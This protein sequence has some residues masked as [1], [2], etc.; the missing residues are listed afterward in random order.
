[1][2]TQNASSTFWK[3]ASS[4]FWRRG[5][6]F[7]QVALAAI[8]LLASVTHAAPLGD[9]DFAALLATFQVAVD[10]ERERYHIPGMTAAFVLPDGRLAKFASGAAD[11][12][13]R[14]AMSPDSRMLSGSIGKTIASAVAVK[15]AEQGVWSLDD[16]LSKYL[17]RNAWYARL[18]NAEHLTVRLLL[19]HR[20][21][22]ENYYDN[23]RFFELLRK[24]TAEDPSYAPTFETLIDFVC[25]RPPLFPPGQGFKYTDVG[26]L[27][28]GLA[29]EQATGTPYYE[30]ARAFFLDPVGL[31]LTSPSNVRRLPGLVQGYAN[32][33]NALLQGPTMIGADGQL[34]Y[35]P[36]I[37]FTAGGFVTNSG[38]LARW[39]KALY[40]S[41]VLSQASV[42][43]ILA[44]PATDTATQDGPAYYGLGVRV[45]AASKE[46][47]ASYGH[48][49]YIPG[50]RSSM[51]YYPEFDVAIALQMNTED[52]IWE[53]ETGGKEAL[54]SH[55]DPSAI[56]ERLSAIVLGAVRQA[57]KVN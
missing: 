51:R 46:E 17:G 38:D 30:T 41:R 25:D 3:P 48:D 45:S 56:R 6:A 24:K 23:P 55:A 4:R 37:E 8:G 44:R 12:E 18:P 47:P 34:T 13:R 53:Q 27:L 11:V 52:G 29:I 2:G 9:R 35:Q 7:G 32:G 15:L 36:S 26:Y 21:G 50:Y 57:A 54:K 5:I 33:Q 14:V 40:S 28:V 31:L 42:A 22:L 49:G 10:A 20:G 19:Q 43:S 16:K 39:A 1:V